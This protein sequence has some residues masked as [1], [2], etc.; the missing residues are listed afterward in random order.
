VNI[1]SAVA[2]ARSCSNH[3]PDTGLGCFRQ[4]RPRLD[5]RCHVDREQFLGF[6]VQQDLRPVANVSPVESNGEVL[7]NDPGLGR[8]YVGPE[9]VSAGGSFGVLRMRGSK[10]SSI[11]RTNSKSFL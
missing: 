10:E 3:C 2:A 8:Q 4:I 9:A 5:W 7:C 1:G 6:P 11:R